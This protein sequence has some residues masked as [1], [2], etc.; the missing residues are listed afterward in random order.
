MIIYFTFALVPITTVKNLVTSSSSCIPNKYTADLCVVYSRAINYIHVQ[1]LLPGCFYFPQL[2]AFQ[3]QI[4][5]ETLATNNATT[6]E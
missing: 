3:V 4:P 2:L 6:N 5:T 1:I